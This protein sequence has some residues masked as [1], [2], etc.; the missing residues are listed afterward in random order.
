MINKYFLKL[1]L[2]TFIVISSIACLA[3]SYT[4]NQSINVRTG[5][6]ISYSI[7]GVIPADSTV[8]VQSIEG[9]WASIQYNNETAYI[10]TKFVS[11][12]GADAQTTTTKKTNSKSDLQT[13]LFI[14]GTIATLL[15]IRFIS[16]RANEIFGFS[17]EEGFKYR[18]TNCGRRSTRR[19]HI[20]KC[21]N[22]AHDWYRM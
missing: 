6:G 8:D 9:N 16:I 19:G 15:I 10:S 2:L 11:K 21:K 5:P 3:E 17:G 14:I 12:P 4:A 22:G 7:A 18:C 20:Y 1:Q 13:I